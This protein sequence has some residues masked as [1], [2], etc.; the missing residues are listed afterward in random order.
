M[1]KPI[2]AA[3]M[4]TVRDFM[5]NDA[6]FVESIKKVKAI[7]YT[8]VQLSG[9]TKVSADVITETLKNENIK[10]CIT[11]SPFDRLLNDFDNIVAEHKAWGCDRIGV[12]GIPGNFP[13]TTEGYREFAKV[14]CEIADE[15][16]KHGMKFAYH[17]HS[18]EFA[19]RDGIS[20][21]DILIGETNDNFEFIPDCFWLQHAGVN[22]YGWLYKVKGRV[23]T[24]H[25]KDFAVNPQNH[26]PMICEIGNGNMDYKLLTDICE[27]LGI[28]YADVEQDTCPGDPFDSLKFSYD[29]LKSIGL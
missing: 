23:S 20:G 8:A 21:M 7:G 18:H 2:I 28:K 11:H 25:Y 1:S 6:D 10:C 27:E 19:K 16:A 13:Q 29:Y 26:Q 17:N 14:A 22:P 4:Y 3:Q 9:H 24:I 12:G 5:Q 15:L